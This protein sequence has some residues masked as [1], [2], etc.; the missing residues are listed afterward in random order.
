MTDSDESSRSGREKKPEQV[1]TDV[2]AL[3]Y[4]VE[5]AKRALKSIKDKELQEIRDEKEME[6]NIR[7][8]RARLAALEKTR[9][10]EKMRLGTE[11]LGRLEQLKA[12]PTFMEAF[13][14]LGE[15]RGGLILY[16]RNL[17]NPAEANPDDA[18]LVGKREV[19]HDF[20]ISG[21]GRLF[22]RNWVPPRHMAEAIAHHD[23]PDEGKLFLHQPEDFKKTCYTSL[24]EFHAFIHSDDLQKRMAAQV[25]ALADDL[26]RGPCRG[27][28][29]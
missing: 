6:R 29:R 8:E 21:D 19:L 23:D 12:D 9:E 24:K 13:K 1:D 27:R 14:L 7:L 2:G 20:R 26:K 15:Y 10:P 22:F 16:E 11:V 17:T 25:K 28:L 4:Q 3:R 5:E 18:W